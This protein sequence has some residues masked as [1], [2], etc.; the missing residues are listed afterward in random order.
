M[1]VSIDLMMRI[2]EEMDRGAEEL[3]IERKELVSWINREINLCL[4]QMKQQKR[5][6]KAG[7]SGYVLALKKI[8]A[9][10]DSQNPTKENKNDR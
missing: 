1:I 4:E 2:G 8:Q 10:L 7:T 6:L 3:L 5:Y 9:K